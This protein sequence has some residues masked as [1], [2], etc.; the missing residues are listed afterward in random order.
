MTD[1]DTRA[2]N[3]IKNILRDG[4]ECIGVSH[5]KSATLF[6]KMKC[7]IHGEYIEKSKFIDDKYNGCKGCVEGTSGILYIHE[8]L[9]N[10]ACIALKF[11]ITSNLTSRIKRQRCGTKYTINN[12]VTFNLG[13]NAKGIENLIKQKIETSF[14]SSD[15][16]SDGY[17]E[18][19]SVLNYSKMLG[20]INSNPEL[21]SQ[22]KNDAN[23]VYKIQGRITKNSSTG[24]IGVF[25]N[26][27][28]AKV[29]KYRAAFRLGDTF[30]NIFISSD[31][32]ECAI[33]HDAYVLDNKLDRTTNLSLGLVT[34]Q[35][36]DS[37]DRS[38]ISTVGK[39]RVERLI[40]KTGYMGVTSSGS[41]QYCAKINIDGKRIKIKTSKD[42]K[43]CAEA[44]DEYITKNNIDKPTNKSLGLI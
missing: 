13:A 40:G 7:H 4:Y 21:P 35:E 42:P 17:T 38:K 16:F 20:I 19:T 12:V 23:M 31:T 34:Q 22:I 26:K 33:A 29:D 3:K 10:G 8:I 15:V 1:K 6:I 37:F 32:K 43:I 36:V 5:R 9:D 14:L 18:T 24:F 41:N 11:G 27:S 30:T 2:I 44:Y 25:K 39:H 28:K